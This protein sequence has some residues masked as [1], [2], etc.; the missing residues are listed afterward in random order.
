MPA[1]FLGWVIE[2]I[3]GKPLDKLA[4]KAFFEP[5]GM[6]NTT[7]HIPKNERQN[8]PPTEIDA[9]RGL[10]QGVV[11]DESAHAWFAHGKVM[12]HAGL[13]SNARDILNFLEM[14]LH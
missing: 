11:H 7:Y 6:K 14:L 1:I 2:R 5:L 13:F 10:V 12:G 4:H 3:H 8:V 9:H